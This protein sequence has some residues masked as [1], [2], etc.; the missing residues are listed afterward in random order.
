MAVTTTPRQIT[1]DRLA[2]MLTFVHEHRWEAERRYDI[3]RTV[4]WDAMQDRLLDM[5][6]R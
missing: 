5:W 3:R 6:A 1:R 4:A 2:R